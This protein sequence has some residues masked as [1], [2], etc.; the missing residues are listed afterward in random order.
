M[1]SACPR[2]AR[3]A[4]RRSTPR[5]WRPGL[6][7]LAAAVVTTALLPASMAPDA[8]AAPSSPEAQADAEASG[9]L[10]VSRDA[11][12]GRVE[13]VTVTGKNADLAP[14]LAGRSASS[15]TAKADSWLTDHADLFG[16]DADDLTL[17]NTHS[18][19]LGRTL[20]YAQSHRGVPVFGARL[21]VNL[22]VEGNLT[23]ANGHLLPGI[24]LD[25]TPLSTAKEAE[26]AAV[27]L[28]RADPPTHDH[29]DHAGGDDE[30]DEPAALDLSD[31]EADAELVVY[32]SGSTA[33][34]SGLVYLA[35]S[36]TVTG[37][38][39]QERVI[40]ADGGLKPLNRWSEAH[41]LSRQLYVWD[42][43]SATTVWAEGAPTSGLTPAHRRLLESTE[44]T[45]NLFRTTFGRD[46]YDGAGATMR[47][48]ADDQSS[49]PNAYWTGTGRYTSFCT[50]VDSDDVV[51]HEW[52]HAYTQFTSGL[53][54]QFQSGALNESYSDVWGE[55]V[56]QL[57]EREDDEEDLSVRTGDACV[58][59]AGRGATIEITAPTSIAGP[60]SQVLLAHDTLPITGTRTVDVVVG[61]TDSTGGSG[62]VRTT[63]GCAPL[64][65]AAAVAGNWVY[66]DRGT[67][68]FA[69]KAG[70]AREAGAAGVVLGNNQPT[71]M[72]T[73]NGVAGLPA[74]M[75]SQADGARF[76]QTVGTSS[77][78]A[79]TGQDPST[80][81]STRWLV[82][83]K[84]SAMGG[85]LRDMWN[86]R[87]AGDPAAVPDA[88][89]VCGTTDSGGVHYNSGV[90]NRAFSLF[91]D[92]G[93]FEDHTVDGVGLDR[94][95][96][97]WWRAQT[98]HLVP[99]SDF[100][101]FAD[102]LTQSCTTLVGAPIKALTVKETTGNVTPLTTH[103]C[104]QL[105]T[106]IEATGLR[107]S[108]EERC[109]LA[110]LVAGEPAG[111]GNGTHQV[112][113]L[114]ED[115]NGETEGWTPEVTPQPGARGPRPWA[116]LADGGSDGSQALYKPTANACA[117]TSYAGRAHVTSPEVTV[118]AD[119]PTTTQLRLRFRH[120]VILE[121]YYDGAQV[122]LVV[123]GTER[124]VPASAWLHNGPT[125]TVATQS[126]EPRAN[127]NPLEGQQVWSGHDPRAADDGWG[128]SLLDLSA[129]G[130]TPGASAAVRFVVGEDYC[131]GNA[132][133][134]VDDVS[135]SYC[136]LDSEILGTAPR[137]FSPTDEQA[138]NL[139]V[140]ASRRGGADRDT[141]V[142]G[143]EVVAS[144]A[145]GTE[146]GRG[147]VARGNTRVALSGLPTGTSRI[148]LEYGG[149]S[150]VGASR[151]EVEVTVNVATPTP[152]PT[153]TD[154][155]TPAPT[156]S[157]SPTAKPSAKPRVKKK[158]LVKVTAS[159]TRP[160]RGKAFTLNARVP[161]AKGGRVTFTI[162]KVKVGSAKVV[163]GRAR[164]KVG[165]RKV[166]R[167][168]LGR[169]N[170]KAS[171][172]GTSTWAPAKGKR[173]IRVR[174]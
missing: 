102:A 23:S 12:T 66:L 29:T 112:S 151:A 61:Y 147:K 50:G 100:V 167:L 92:G 25:H 148:R 54:Y 58:P 3:H 96:H 62:S 135:I 115:F 84:A 80:D 45:Y 166:A 13:F 129:A 2:T 110:Q 63:D 139:E 35:W 131:A 87:C 132:G 123:D 122:R 82:G 70:H 78:V 120:R 154:T 172:S 130:V 86:P 108:T 28:V 109:N 81:R 142:D 168:K 26:R 95:A 48:A 107:T 106:V 43:D 150:D 73:F 93:T 163:K 119:L 165:A 60:C 128:T 101:D 49:C 105:A 15:A 111:C 94:A 11:T 88:Q 38:G 71:P 39:I 104:T 19:Q 79:I 169:Q 145:D 152:A 72:T 75:V 98:A 155:P 114:D 8:V 30:A 6:A 162:G 37:G 22:D 41:G 68:T 34:S 65:N 85:E 103:D 149:H 125:V 5:G 137:T 7:A 20:T 174:R 76:R 173:V 51:A 124:T 171:F 116:L 113:L 36:L 138:L 16:V 143:G 32:E 153:P 134:I 99:T 14:S 10:D 31:L 9:R 146:L 69:D 140:R 53:V 170:V 40:L 126:S 89:Y 161:N 24:D 160:R 21:K 67:C 144:L 133:W 136:A 90:P 27:S 121:S 18:D 33:S 141:T 42:G 17:V 97:V 1:S 127:R 91:V 55:V 77:T 57:N 56:D 156:S 159:T 74:L 59:A 64:T 46:S 47:V 157:P 158:T 44:E 164:L 4:A 52:G 83:E 118:P 117:S